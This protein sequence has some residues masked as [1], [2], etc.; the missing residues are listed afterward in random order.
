MAE[1]LACMLQLFT[2]GPVV[3]NGYGIGYFIKPDHMTFNVTA[4]NKTTKTT[5]S[6][7]ASAVDHAMQQMIAL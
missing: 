7:F 2:F 3:S 4:W 5:A 6:D 1:R